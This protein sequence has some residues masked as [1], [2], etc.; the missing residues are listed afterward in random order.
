MV[1]IP[2]NHDWY[3]GLTA[4]GRQ[5]M[6]PGTNVGAFETGQ[7]RS[8]WAL[9]V[10]VDGRRWWLWGVDMALDAD[11]DRAQ[12]DY[13]AECGAVAGEP[14][15]LFVAAP[16]WTYAEHRSEQL[17][18][19]EQRAIFDRGLQLVLVLSGDRHYYMRRESGVPAE[20]G[21]RRPDAPPRIT[22][23]LGGAFKHPPHLEKAVPMLWESGSDRQGRSRRT[24]PYIAAQLPGGVPWRRDGA[25]D[26][27]EGSPS[28]PVEVSFPGE[29]GSRRMVG[30]RRSL[31]AWWRWNRSFTLIPLVISLITAVTTLQTSEF[32]RQ[33]ADFSETSFW[34]L[35]TYMVISFNALV[36]LLIL[37]LAFFLAAPDPAAH[38]QRAQRLW[39]TVVH[40]L[41]HVIALWLSMWAAQR[42]A[43]RWLDQIGTDATSD[44]VWE[45]V[46][47]LTISSVLGALAFTAVL[48]LYFWV[49]NRVQ[50][51]VNALA[52]WNMEQNYVGFV[53]LRFTKDSIIGEVHGVTDVKVEDPEKIWS[54]VADPRGTEATVE[55][56]WERAPLVLVDHFDIRRPAG[57]PLLPDR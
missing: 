48:L 28:P 16:L 37:G 17:Y 39:W 32:W 10:M 26:E 50:M 54:V 9:D 51:S 40:A 20:D 22:A 12:L 34:Q 21:G 27:V 5:F 57:E 6:E 7:H 18:Q 11:V 46:A 35:G 4:F 30:I 13:F 15:V 44:R 3:D 31:S 14:V 23:G 52:S 56:R 33:D 41:A 38:L 55:P 42:I 36:L 19:F 1:A 45:G 8:Y 25:A 53:R 49:T 29:Q 24:L 43:A 2:G 47:F